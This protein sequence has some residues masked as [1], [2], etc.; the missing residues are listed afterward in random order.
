[1]TTTAVPVEQNSRSLEITTHIILTMQS[2]MK[3]KD[4]NMLMMTLLVIKMMLIRIMMVEMIIKMMM[5]IE[6]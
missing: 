3:V 2:L 4:H 6:Q 5:M 1:M